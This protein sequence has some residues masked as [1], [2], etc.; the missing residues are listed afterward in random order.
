MLKENWI[1]SETCEHKFK[2]KN[3]ESFPNVKRETSICRLCKL[4][5]VK[6]IPTDL[7]KETNIF[8]IEPLILDERKK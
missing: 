1:N 7:E 2:V 3:V 4:K 5:M 8:F 6:Q